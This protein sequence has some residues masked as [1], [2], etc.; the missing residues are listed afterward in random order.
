MSRLIFEFSARKVNCVSHSVTATQDRNGL[1]ILLLLFFSAGDHEKSQFFSQGEG[2]VREGSTCR[3]RE[4]STRR[5]RG[6]REA[7]AYKRSR[8]I[9]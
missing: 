2:E 1:K 9:K 3:A 4:G 7:H 6:E 8:K 5:A